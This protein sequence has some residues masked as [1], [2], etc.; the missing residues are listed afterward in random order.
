MGL[1]FSSCAHACRST[2]EIFA[3]FIS[4]AFAVDAFKDVACGETSTIL[5]IT[6]LILI[7]RSINRPLT[8]GQPCSIENS[9]R[10]VPI[11][12]ELVVSM[13]L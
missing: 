8:V 5:L 1:L 9:L 6:L 7:N 4:M 13:V 12:N 3:L 11:L 10:S 2:E